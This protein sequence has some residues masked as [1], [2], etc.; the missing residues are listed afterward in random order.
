MI[1]LAAVLTFLSALMIV[2]GVRSRR[3]DPVEAR[4]AAIRAGVRPQ[5]SPLDRPFIDRAVVPTFSGLA[6]ALMRLL[7]TTWLETSSPPLLPRRLGRHQRA[8]RPDGRP[9]RR[10]RRLSRS[11]ALAQ[12]P[13]LRAPVPGPQAVA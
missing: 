7:P 8:P 2:S 11:P 9:R 13:H 4:L 3:A 5:R 1:P 10:R 12:R 6:D